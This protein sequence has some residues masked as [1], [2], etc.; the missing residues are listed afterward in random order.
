MRHEYAA[1]GQLEE[2]G[3]HLGDAGRL[4]DHG[5]GDAGEHRDK[6][7]DALLGIHQRLKLAQHLA[8][9]HLDR[10]DLGDAR[11]GLRRAARG[12]EVD[13]AER[14]VAQR[15]TEVVEA[16][17]VGEGTRHSADARRGV[18]QSGRFPWCRRRGGSSPAAASLWLRVDLRSER[19]R[20]ERWDSARL[21]LRGSAG[22]SPAA[23]SLW[24]RIGWSPRGPRPQQGVWARVGLRGAATILHLCGIHARL[25]LR[26]DRA[27]RRKNRGDDQGPRTGRDS[28][29][30]WNGPRRGRIS[31]HPMHAGLCR[32][33][34]SAFVCRNPNDAALVTGSRSQRNILRPLTHERRIVRPP[35]RAPRAHPSP[36]ASAGRG[37]FGE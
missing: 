24:L 26:V 21:G 35:T 11:P 20:P 3:Q 9:A 30:A 1:G 29:F 25:F 27:S 19:P 36:D 18:R 22:I 37:P 12:L 6:R 13:D 14:D 10:T 7:R 32:T 5:V 31:A 28:P 23:A 4:D 16:G 2:A 34:D 15:S 8:T 33:Q 17:L